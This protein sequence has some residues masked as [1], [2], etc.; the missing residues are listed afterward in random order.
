MAQLSPNL[1]HFAAATAAATLTTSRKLMR[2]YAYYRNQHSKT[3]TI[4]RD[5]LLVL[6]HKIRMY[7]FGLHNL[8]LDEENRESPFL[9]ALAGNINDSF[10][11]MHRKIL[12]FDAA[13]IETMIPVIDAQRRFWN[14]YTNENFYQDHLATFLE[15]TLPDDIKQ[16]NDIIE[17]L[18]KQTTL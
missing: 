7:A 13:D 16:L 10:E 9:V 4:F 3:E 18:P 14:Q 2:N 6:C 11:E 17:T 15:N 1:L 8:L 12:F 5:D